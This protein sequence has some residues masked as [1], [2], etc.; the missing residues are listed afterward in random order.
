[1][2]KNAANSLLAI[3]LAPDC[4][5]VLET[6]WR[7]GT[8]SVRA[9]AAQPLEEDVAATLP[10]RHLGALERV[11]ATLRPRARACA[12]AMS[13]SLVTT[14]AVVIDP[15]KPQPPEEQIK[16]T[17]QAVLSFD[18]R[19]LLFDHWTVT[20]PGE[21]NRAYEV[22]VVAAQRSVVYHYL[23][24]FR[25]LGLDCTHI[26]VVPCALAGLLPRLLPQ[27]RQNLLG[28]VVL[29]KTMGCFSVVRNQDVLFWRPFDLPSAKKNGPLAIL[30]RIG[31]EVSKCLSHMVG[32]QHL[33]QLAEIVLFGQAASE[34][35]CGDYLASRFGVQ[36]HTPSL[37]QSLGPAPDMSPDV[38]DAL[39]AATGSQ[40]AVALGLACQLAGGYDG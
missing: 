40:F 9:L 3:D 37:I 25:R 33:D 26:D 39:Q 31:D 12:A 18:A 28:T 17:L 15:A 36:I 19:D 23:D 32:S 5:R 29:G 13:T 20:P 6:A 30:E 8:L 4:V 34:G 1:M 16:Q 14:R 35:S 27:H 21:K 2:F 7:R 10:A 22:L 11:F 38:A 24:G